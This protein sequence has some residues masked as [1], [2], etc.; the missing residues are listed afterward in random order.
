[1]CPVLSNAV[2]L[3]YSAPPVTAVGL[4]VVRIVI[5]TETETG[6]LCLICNI[7]KMSP[8]TETHRTKGRMSGNMCLPR[9][10]RHVRDRGGQQRS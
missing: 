6:V 7:H 10:N 2:N 8:E 5:E 4:F 3:L 1:M 9:L